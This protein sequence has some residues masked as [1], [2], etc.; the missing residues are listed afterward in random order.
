MGGADVRLA[1]VGELLSRHLEQGDP[2]RPYADR[3]REPG[4]GDQS[5]RGYLTGSID[6]VLRVPDPDG[7]PTGSATSSSTTRPTTSASPASR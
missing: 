4:L 3:L 5:L 6:V 1:D 7:R 2:F